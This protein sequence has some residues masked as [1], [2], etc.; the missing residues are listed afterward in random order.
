MRQSDGRL[1]Y[2][3]PKDEAPLQGGAGKRRG[4][5]DLGSA[6]LGNRAPAF[7]DGADAAT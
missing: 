3:R 5:L 6:G 4:R 1:G 7:T 2:G